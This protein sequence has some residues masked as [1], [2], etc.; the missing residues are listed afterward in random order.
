[1]VWLS[2]EEKLRSI[3]PDSLAIAEGVAPPLGYILKDPLIVKAE[4]LKKVGRVKRWNDAQRFAFRS[5]FLPL[6][7]ASIVE[8]NPLSSI[9]CLK[10]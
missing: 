6:S 3:E 2:F 9:A 5:L 7:P 1:M 4:R 8:E 10:I